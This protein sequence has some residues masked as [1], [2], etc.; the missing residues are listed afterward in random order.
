MPTLD[1]LMEEASQALVRTDYLRCEELCLEALAEARHRGEWDYYARIL[2]PLQEARRQRRMIAAEGVIRLGTSELASDPSEW[3]DYMPSGCIVVTQPHA[4]DHAASLALEAR[5]GTVERRERKK[6]V[7]VLYAD[8]LPEAPRWTLR[9]YAGPDVTCDFPAPPADWLNRWINVPAEPAP[10]KPTEAAGSLSHLASQA[11]AEPAPEAG[12]KRPADWV[13]DAAEALGDAALAR[14]G[15]GPPSPELLR[16]LERCL[17][18]VT[19]HEIIHQ[20]LAAT[21]R[22]LGRTGAA[23]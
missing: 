8:N 19:D 4:R 17:E 16:E 13:L 14:V 15:D 10:T 6:Y 12:C 2:L 21:A 3:L 20:R 5:A 1:E 7:E 22:A 9:S 23:R 18:V 11:A